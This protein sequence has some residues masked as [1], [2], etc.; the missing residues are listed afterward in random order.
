MRIDSGVGAAIARCGLVLLAGA[1]WGQTAGSARTEYVRLGGQVVATV[2][3]PERVFTDFA[4]TVFDP[5]A[6]AAALMFNLG[7]TGGC[8][9]SPRQYCPQ[10]ELPR[11]A[12]AVFVIRA[13][14]V[15]RYGSA[16]GFVT[17]APPSATPHFGDVPDTQP[18]FKYI[19]K[20]WELGISNG[21]PSTPPAVYYC[22]GALV[23]IGHSAAF[24]IRA[25]NAIE[26]QCA[27][28]GSDP[29]CALTIDYEYNPSPYFADMGPSDGVWFQFAQLAVKFGA[30]SPSVVIQTVPACALG[31][32][33]NT[34]TLSRGQMATFVTRVILNE[35]EY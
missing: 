34:A 9:A 29:N 24:S 3:T 22:P 15:R 17:Q 31:S 5:F 11:D 2:S 25:R 13:W 6:D 35:P 26:K 14:S 7:I 10:Y 16:E 21:C 27:A 19:Q 8:V 18:F 33:C 32:Y 20:M 28:D 4:N 30:V 1:A 12:M 23:T